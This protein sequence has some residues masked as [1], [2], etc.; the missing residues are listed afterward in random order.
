MYQIS[1]AL[2]RSLVHEVAVEDSR[3]HG[4]IRRKLLEACEATVHRLATDRFYFA[5]P[6]R[7]LFR[8]IRWCFPVSA[9]PRV[10]SIIDEQL[11]VVAERFA[12][13]PEL[14][15]ALTGHRMSCRA[16][17]RKGR[18]CGRRPGRDG[19]CPSHKH[20]ADDVVG[21]HDYSL[22]GHAPVRP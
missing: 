22:A 14:V 21:T 10:Y 3:G 7:T 6:A 1:R 19:Y 13:D 9:Q 20:L 17:A 16:W 18:P 15:F 11:S 2:Y 12:E 8:D 5:H 4:D